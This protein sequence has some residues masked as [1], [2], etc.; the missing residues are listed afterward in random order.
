MEGA[1]GRGTRV[2]CP[3]RFFRIIG[4][5]IETER[6]NIPIPSPLDIGPFRRFWFPYD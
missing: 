3:T 2:D 5:R 6:G 1:G 4:E